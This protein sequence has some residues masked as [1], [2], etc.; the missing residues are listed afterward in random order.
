MDYDEFQRAKDI[1]VLVLPLLTTAVGYWLGSQGTAKAE[2]KT[3]VAQKQK[4]ALLGAG[5][6]DL[7][8]KGA[9]PQSVGVWDD[10]GRR[11]QVKDP[12][13]NGNISVFF[14]ADEVLFACDQGHWWTCA[15]KASGK[16]FQAAKPKAGTA[17]HAS[18]TRLEK[19]FGPEPVRMMRESS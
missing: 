3:E 1:F 16:V 14:S 13:D 6:D 5:S 9:T 4:E 7:L 2:E 8:T 19:K 15:V 11:I 17:M 10:D 12:D 18:M